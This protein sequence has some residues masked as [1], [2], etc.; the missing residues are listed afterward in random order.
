MNQVVTGALFAGALFLGIL[1]M[2]ET[3]RYLRRRQSGKEIISNSSGLNEIEGALF[4][5]MA[6]ILA[7][8]FSGA[9]SRLDA[10]RQLIVD[11]ANCIGTAYLRLEL[12][13]PEPKQDLQEKFR[14]YVD[15]R[16]SAY[17]ALPDAAKAKSEVNRAMIIQGEIWTSAVAACQQANSSQTSMLLLNS[18]NAMFDIAN[19]RY[20][21]T[22][23]H[24]PVLVYWLMSILVLICSLLAGFSMGDNNVRNRIYI[25]SFA[26]MLAIT[27]YTIIDLDHPRLG[28]IQVK[29][30]DQAI[31]DVRN[32]MDV[33]K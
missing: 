17:R 1:L 23:M 33:A 10:R 31:V 29:D 3:G 4:G 16:L 27:V 14:Q 20:L 15:A 30:F 8:S 13:S 22:K 28:L 25:F 24:Q 11:E 19:T 21:A 26:M 5:L 2:L 9:G 32:S 6:L 12:L 7:F 18:L